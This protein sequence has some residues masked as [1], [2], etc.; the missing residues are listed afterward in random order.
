VEARQ[1]L[2][3]YGVEGERSDSAVVGGFDLPV[4]AGPG[5]A[6]AQAALGDI[7]LSE[8]GV[9]G[10]HVLPDCGDLPVCGKSVL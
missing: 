7:A 1:W 8:A 4:F 2:L 9:A 3:F 5:S 10:S 6:E